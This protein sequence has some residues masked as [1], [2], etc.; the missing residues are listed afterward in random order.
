MKNKL[1]YLGKIN[2]AKVLVLGCI[3]IMSLFCGEVAKA[4][5]SVTILSSTSKGNVTGDNAYDAK[6]ITGISYIQGTGISDKD[7]IK[8]EL[9]NAYEDIDDYTA[10][11]IWEQGFSSSAGVDFQDY[12]RWYIDTIA[13]PNEDY[14]NCAL[15]LDTSADKD[16]IA[17]DASNRFIT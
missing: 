8:F 7:G 3:F 6:T 13:C 14:A 12:D 11:A 10:I 16:Y 9:T 15:Q 1:F 2:I 4:A 17:K 5:P